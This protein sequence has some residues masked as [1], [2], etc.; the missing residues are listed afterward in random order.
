[1]DNDN[2]GIINLDDFKI[3]C[4]NSLGFSRDEL[5]IYKLQRVLQAISLT[6]NNNIGLA[7]IKEL[8]NKAINKSDFIDLKEK[9]K[10]TI[11]QNLFKGK[12]NTEWINEIIEKFGMFISERYNSVEEFFHKANADLLPCILHRIG[13]FL[14]H[15]HILRRRL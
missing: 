12:E 6:K 2:D 9:F 7:D 1:M 14:R 11:N 8:T 4:I 13:S 5:N 3:F 10:E 15:A